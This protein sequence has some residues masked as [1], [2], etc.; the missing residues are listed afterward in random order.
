MAD[1]LTDLTLRPGRVEDAAALRALGEAV[2]PATYGPLDP[3]CAAMMLAR[4]WA[5]D[6]LA[7]SLGHLPHVVAELDGRLVGDAPWLEHVDGNDAAAGFHRG[8]GFAEVERVPQ[9]PYPD[10]VWMRKDL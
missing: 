8:H 3:A 5:T 4:W 7:E 2:V 10:D 6:R 9:P 1:T